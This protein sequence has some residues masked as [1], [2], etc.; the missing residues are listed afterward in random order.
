MRTEVE[1]SW[2]PPPLEWVT[3]NSDGSVYTDLGHAAAGG[4][5]Q[6]HTGF[7]LAA[8][9]INLWSCSITRAELRGAVEGLQLAWD[10][11]FRRG[12][13]ELDSF[14]AVQLFGSLDSPDHQQ[15]SII[16]RNGNGAG[17][18]R[19][20]RYPYPPRG[21]SGNYHARVEAG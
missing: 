10:T 7:C 5:I 19:V 12:R 17:P 21:R 13:V 14:Y 16:H 8:Y 11:G 2:K 6:D 4:L 15:A 3:L 20:S 1:I 18:G 9:A